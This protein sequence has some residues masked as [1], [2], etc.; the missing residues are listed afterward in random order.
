MKKQ[1]LTLLGTLLLSTTAQQMTAQIAFSIE[2]EKASQN[3]PAG[4]TAVQLPQNIPAITAANTF[5]ITDYGA[6]T[7]SADNT[8]AI[9]AALNDAASAGGGMVVVPAGEWL[10]G[11]I[12]IGHRTILH[13]CAGAML[14]V[15]AFA[16]QPDHTTKTPYITNK[17]GASD[18]VIVIEGESKET[19]IIEGQGGPW[20]DAVEQKVSGLQR[21]SL[22]RFE[23]GTGSRFLFR[24]FR[25]QNAPST[26]LTLGNSGRGTHNT[27]HDVSIYAP[28]SHGVADP[29][30]NT[31][32]IPIWAAYANIYNCDI[33]TGDDNVVTDSNAQFI[34]VWNCHFKAG[35]GASL[36]SYTVNMHDI[37]YEGITFEGTDCGFRLKSNR[38][39]SGDV[40]N[41]VFRNCTMTG[42][43]NPIQITAWYDTL[44][45]SPAAAAESPEAVISTT[46]RF[47]DITF[48]NVTAQGYSGSASGKNG[49][50][51]FIYG[52]PESL[53]KDVTFKNVRIS[54]AGGMKLNFCEGITFDEQCWY[55]KTSNGKT[56]TA[57]GIS[58]VIDETYNA[59][60]TWSGTEP[61][62]SGATLSGNTY[63]AST[64][65]SSS[66]NFN[67]GYSV[68]NANNKDYA[69]GTS[70][71]VKYSADVQY[72]IVPPTGKAIAAVTFTGYANYDEGSYLKEV[73][74]A[75]Y[76]ATVYPY[77]H[78]SNK[79]NFRSHTITFPTPVAGPV[80]FTPGNKQ[81]CLIITLTVSNTTGIED[82]VQ[83]SK[84]KVQ[85][86]F[87]LQGRKVASPTR[88]IYIVN[89][90]KVIIK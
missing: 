29:S 1:F 18:I 12:Q 86:Y 4:W 78:D 6:S 47:H 84:F 85:S 17:S 43:M 38:D 32:G 54:Q 49:Y 35:H 41:L 7:S 68:T 52:R 77:I 10:F 8:S 74:G 51:I 36:G 50:G 71:T 24:H 25:M 15:L 61:D 66:Y 73:N 48:E 88:G 89:G 34:H 79:S 22:I 62:V 58:D 46:P 80:T 33:D 19:S 3:T 83:S 70:G 59:T 81:T 2:E 37:I 44:P 72:T 23:N 56:S 69:A 60:Y 13:L 76:D 45:T 5:N 67:G 11:R 55:L 26:N 27:V 65:S 39:R 16:D 53:V 87:D 57:S 9:Q 82:A 40:Y 42:V 31:D 64:S 20:W 90:K 21:G 63:N 14:K 75:E 28:A 30:H